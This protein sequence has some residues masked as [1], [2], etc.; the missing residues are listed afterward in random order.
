M[1]STLQSARHNS[2]PRFVL[3]SVIPGLNKKYGVRRQRPE[4]LTI[5]GLGSSRCSSEDRSDPNCSPSIYLI[6][7]LS[8]CLIVQDIFRPLLSTSQETTP[9]FHSSLSLSRPTV[10]N[11]SNSSE[12]SSTHSSN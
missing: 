3:F 11:S 5:L 6:C 1:C 7:L 8:G 12:H 9:S 10:C 2:R 4:A